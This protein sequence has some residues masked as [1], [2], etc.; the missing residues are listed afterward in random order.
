MRSLILTV[1]ALLALV[2]ASPRADEPPPRQPPRAAPPVP[3]GRVAVAPDPVPA[4]GYRPRAWRPG[5]YSPSVAPLWYGW[6]WG[7]YP[8]Y[9]RPM[10]SWGPPPEEV[11]RVAA[12]LR[13]TGG[14]SSSGGAGGVALA[15]EGHRTGFEVAADAFTAASSTTGALDRTGTLGLATAHL[16]WAIASEDAFRLRL[17]LGGSMLS[18]PDRGAYAGTPY[19]GNTAFGPDVGISGSLGLLGPLGLEGHARVTQLPVP[20]TDLRAAMAFRGGPFALS[21]GWRSIE[22]AGDGRTGPAVHFDGPELGL[23]VIF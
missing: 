5:W 17:E 12:T 15:V 9:P 11:E 23:A 19:A 22:V 4:P 10:R 16:T 3:R 7:Y 14:G 6:G 21:L 13:I 1:A 8:L 20:V 18:M 2:P